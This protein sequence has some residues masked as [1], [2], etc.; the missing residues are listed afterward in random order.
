MALFKKLSQLIIKKFFETALPKIRRKMFG[1]PFDDRVL[2]KNARYM[3][4]SPNRKRI[5]IRV[6]L[7]HRE[8]YNRLGNI[9]HL[10]LLLPVQLLAI[11]LKSLHSTASKHPVVS[12]MMQEK[13]RNYYIPSTA[14]YVRNWLQECG[15]CS[16]D[17]RI[18][19]IKLEPELFN[20]PSW[21]MGP[22]MPCIETYT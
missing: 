12:Q 16:N 19:N 7:L 3:N 9:S 4:Y 18:K 20:V 15:T 22:E 21:D 8:Y 6:D 14:K 5:V 13:R 1:L 11:F 17:K 10:Q 2:A